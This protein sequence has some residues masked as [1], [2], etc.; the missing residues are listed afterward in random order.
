VEK[1][2]DNVHTE[3]SPELRPYSGEEQL[4]LGC[5]VRVQLQLGCYGRVQLSGKYNGDGYDARAWLGS[6]ALL[7]C[8]CVCTAIVHIRVYTKREQTSLNM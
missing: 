3:R 6:C 1:A 2:L 5:Y 4:R 8:L 7:S